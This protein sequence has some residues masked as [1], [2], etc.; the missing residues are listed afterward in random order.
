MDAG[1]RSRD[2]LL[3]GVAHVGREERPLGNDFTEQATPSLDVED[4]PSLNAPEGIRG[5]VLRFAG[6]DWMVL[7]FPCTPAGQSKLTPS[8]RWVALALNQGL[9]NAEIARARG[10]SVRTVANQ[11]ARMFRKFSVH[12]RT[13][14]VR[15]LGLEPANGVAK[16]SCR[17]ERRTP[18]RRNRAFL[19]ESA[20]SRHR[21]VVVDPPSSAVLRRLAREIDRV[22]AEFHDS[23][24][25][26]AS[27]FWQSLIRGDF[28]VCDRFQGEGRTMLIARRQDAAGDKPALSGRVRKVLVKRALGY[29]LKVIA[30][31]LGIAQSTASRELKRGLHALGMTSPSELP[32]LQPSERRR[33]ACRRSS[34][35]KSR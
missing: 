2:A 32:P 28:I 9:S 7:S 4:E 13:E 19:D 5:T 30:H 33:L 17:A 27:V 15:Q 14:L 10:T 1:S 3:G 22:C 29:P 23:D 6:A 8:E 34:D 12:T 25:D 26:R 31:E 20:T 35:Q 11:V 16:E 24:A 18:T 21:A